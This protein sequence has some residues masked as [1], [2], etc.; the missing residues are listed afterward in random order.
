METINTNETAARLR[1]SV[2]RLNRR[3]RQSAL[4]GISPAQASMLSSIEIL[5]RPSLG[6]LAVREQ[7]QPP[8]VTRLVRTLEEAGLVTLVPDE[9]D[10]RCTRVVLHPLGKK[11]LTNIRRRKTEFLEAQLLALPLSEQ[12]RAVELADLLEQ[13]LEIQ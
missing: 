11:E 2:T 8:S 1:R 4:G 5:V 7:I 12:R 10:R 6:D 9:V 3:L 13:L